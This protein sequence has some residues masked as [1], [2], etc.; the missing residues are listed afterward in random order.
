AGGAGWALRVSRV[1]PAAAVVRRAPSRPL[2]GRWP[3][4]AR[5]PGPGLRYPSPQGARGGLDLTAPQ[6]R[7]L[8]RHT[9]AVQSRAARENWL[10]QL[11]RTRADAAVSGEAP[12]WARRRRV[13]LPGWP[14]A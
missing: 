1:R 11:G 14:Q 8:G 7:T 3:D 2:G 6:G 12:P 13:G 10:S 4:P 9:A 5:Q